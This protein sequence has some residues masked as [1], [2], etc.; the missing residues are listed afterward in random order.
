MFFYSF[1]MSS[2]G[3]FSK[4][5]KIYMKKGYSKRTGRMKRGFWG[6]Q[7]KKK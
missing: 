3:M 7:I 6:A 5:K 4:K 1:R 2:Q